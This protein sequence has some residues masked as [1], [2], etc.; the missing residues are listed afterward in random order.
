[1]VVLAVLGWGGGSADF[2]GSVVV[3]IDFVQ[4]LPSWDVLCMIGVDPL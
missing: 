2:R 4:S 1:M 3:F